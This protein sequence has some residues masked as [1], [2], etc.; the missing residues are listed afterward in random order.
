M[1]KRRVRRGF[2]LIE[3]MVVVV[4]IGMLAT[5]MVP[6]VFKKLGKAKH[7]IARAKMA[8][9][10]SALADFQLDCER[11]PTESEGGLEALLTAPDD[12][13]E[14][15]S[16]W[17]GPYLKKSDLLD[18]W[19]NPYIY[20]EEGER[21]PGSYDLVSLGADGDEGGEDDKKDIYNE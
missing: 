13:Q 9:L 17:N 16:K 7:T 19:D 11:L 1:N 20:V 10:E 18:P 3:I 5:I 2:T 21:N 4:I 15:D 8:T 12:M 14:E 6:K